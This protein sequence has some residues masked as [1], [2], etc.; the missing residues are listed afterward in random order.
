MPKA[1]WPTVM[2]LLVVIF[3]VIGLYHVAFGRK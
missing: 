3:A 2:V 1:H